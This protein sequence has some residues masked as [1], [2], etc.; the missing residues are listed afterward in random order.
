MIQ[1][2]NSLFIDGGI[3]NPT[4]YAQNGRAIAR[5]TA[6]LRTYDKTIYLESNDNTS[7]EAEAFALVAGIIEANKTNKN[8]IFTDSKFWFDVVNSDWKIRKERL[9]LVAAI[10]KALL[11]EY[12]LELKWV[13]RKENLA[14]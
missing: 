11:E 12:K 1:Q 10:I 6:T 9:K 4:N 7:Q 14:T 2:Q 5:V 3:L 13:P 8:I